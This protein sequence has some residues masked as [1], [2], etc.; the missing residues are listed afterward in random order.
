MYSCGW[1][2]SFTSLVE[3]CLDWNNCPSLIKIKEQVLRHSKPTS[4][5]ET[6]LDWNNCPSLI[7]ITE[8]VLR[9]SKPTSL[10]ET[11]LDWNNCPSLIKITEQVLRHSKP[12]PVPQ[13]RMLPHAE[14]NNM[15]YH[16]MQCIAQTMRSQHVCLSVC[17]SHA[18]LC[19]NS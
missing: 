14:F 3:T 18:V 15:N 10:V 16:A 9:H 7:K 6:C 2:V 19:R 8:Q 12:C 11:C 13:C 17:L 1:I 4:L 5:V